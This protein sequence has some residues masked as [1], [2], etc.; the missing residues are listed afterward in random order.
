MN[1]GEL[2]IVY[3]KKSRNTYENEIENLQKALLSLSFHK[4]S[5][6]GSAL[7]KCTVIIFC[8]LMKVLTSTVHGIL[9][10]ASIAATLTSTG[11][12]SFEK[13]FSRYKLAV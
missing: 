2:M 11:K 5:Q 9:R 6:Y 3:R 13:Q 1:N 8:S 10:R 4:K 12:S 7:R